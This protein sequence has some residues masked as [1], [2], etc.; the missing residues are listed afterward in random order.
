L[1]VTKKRVTLRKLE[2]KDLETCWKYIY[3]APNPEWKKWECSLKA[4]CENAAITTE[5]IMIPFVWEF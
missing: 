2:E 5:N 3:G 1:K 4:E